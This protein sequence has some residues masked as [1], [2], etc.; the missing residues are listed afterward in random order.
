M[1]RQRYEPLVAVRERLARDVQDQPA[2]AHIRP[3]F[4]GVDAAFTLGDEEPAAARN[5]Y[6][7]GRVAER[8]ASEHLFDVP[9]A[10]LRLGAWR[11]REK[12]RRFGRSVKPGS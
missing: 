9:A 7:E 5:L 12:G 3:L 10:Q 4:E 1:K 2:L 6:D 11:Q 8:Q